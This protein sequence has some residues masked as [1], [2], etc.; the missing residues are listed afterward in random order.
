MELLYRRAA[1]S[2]EPGNSPPV[3]DARA[4]VLHNHDGA[5]ANLDAF[6]NLTIDSN[7][8]ALNDLCDEAMKKAVGVILTATRLSSA[9]TVK[10][11]KE[12]P[13]NDT[14]TAQCSGLGF[15]GHFCPDSYAALAPR[16]VIRSS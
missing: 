14:E 9:A 7:P 16:G 4:G 3:D 1:P 5:A 10:D 11:D 13:G 8:S 15:L 6:K 2:A 12:A